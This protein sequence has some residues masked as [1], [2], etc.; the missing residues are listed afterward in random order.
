MPS[1]PGQQLAR[2]PPEARA[3]TSSAITPSSPR[4]TFTS[5]TPPRTRW[6]PNS[7]TRA[8]RRRPS[9]MP[10]SAS[11]R[12]RWSKRSP[13]ARRSCASCS[14]SG[15]SAAAL[16]E[17][18]GFPRRHPRPR[19]CKEISTTDGRSLAAHARVRRSGGARS[20]GPADDAQP[21][22]HQRPAAVADPRRHLAGPVR[23]GHHP[24]VLLRSAARMWLVIDRRR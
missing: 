20:Q 7:A 17:K 18:L 5:T 23:A 21:A 9:T 4:S 8:G 15:A 1:T 22:F 11:P 2:P 14:A 24:L 12:N 13:R 19:S 16:V 6:R 10:T 3:P